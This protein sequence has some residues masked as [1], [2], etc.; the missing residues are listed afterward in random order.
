MEF[1]GEELPLPLAVVFLI[2][3]L[4]S[5]SVFSMRF[6]GYK[7]PM[8]GLRSIVEHRLTANYRFFRNAGVVINEGYSK[9]ILNY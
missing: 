2:A 6:L 8:V 5:S 7:A 9:V 4:Y 3:L 1:L